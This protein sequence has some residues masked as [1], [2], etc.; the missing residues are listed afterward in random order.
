MKKEL[1]R[2]LGLGFKYNQEIILSDLSF[3]VVEGETLS[4]VGS[5]GVGKTVLGN[6][7]SG[8]LP[9]QAGR[10]LYNG[11]ELSE[12]ECMEKIAYIPENV[13]LLND[14]TV[15]E[16]VLIGNDFSFNTFFSNKKSRREVQ[17]YLDKYN[18]DIRAEQLGMEL[19]IAKKSMV[20]LVRQLIARPKL[21][22]V[23][24]S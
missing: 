24:S 7:L 8:R 6:V 20:L 21:L 14:M 13:N 18:L 4:I 3:S 22:I 10:I 12:K 5:N 23:D 17:T 19:S 15:M 16:N 1:L 9:A 11:K 2:V